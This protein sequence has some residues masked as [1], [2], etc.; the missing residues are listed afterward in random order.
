[1]HPLSTVDDFAITVAMTC[2]SLNGSMLLIEKV[3]R[4]FRN[5]HANAVNWPSKLFPQEIQLTFRY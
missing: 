5:I 1:M 3:N 2:E 4:G